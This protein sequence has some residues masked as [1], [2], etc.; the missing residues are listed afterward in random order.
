M[1]MTERLSDYYPCPGCPFHGFSQVNQCEPKGGTCVWLLT[2]YEKAKRWDQLPEIRKDGVVDYLTLAMKLEAVKT[3]RNNL[4]EALP[5]GGF[6]AFDLIK[7]I[8]THIAE[9]DGVLDGSGLQ[10]KGDKDEDC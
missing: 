7:I 10:Q 3:T 4:Y 2:M 5:V 1:K 9:L 8:K 6:D